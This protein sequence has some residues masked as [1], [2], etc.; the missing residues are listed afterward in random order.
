MIKAVIFDMD[1]T[2][3][4]TEPIYHKTNSELYKYLCLNINQTENESFV[5]ID[6]KKKW[7]YIKE[8]GKLSHPLKDLIALSKKYK[9]AALGKT[10]IPVF[11]GITTLIEE[12]INREIK[13]ALAS[14]S[15]WEI[16]NLNLKSTGLDKYFK[17]KVSGEDI[18]NGKPAP[19]IFLAT[20]NLI[21]CQA[22]ECMVIEDS[23]NGVLGA[24]AAGMACIAHNVVNSNQDLDMA[25]LVIDSY[26]P[27]NRKKIFSLIDKS[28]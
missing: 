1:G 4:D 23:K 20:A 21:S 12:L 3:V 18:K 25:H 2:L 10:R 24:L 15:N 8:K 16:I 14:S 27:V 19:D 22:N 26:S 13:I 28:I 11:K 9:I 5:G 17:Y 6:S 7:S